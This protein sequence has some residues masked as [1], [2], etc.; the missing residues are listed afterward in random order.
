MWRKG[1]LTYMATIHSALQAGVIH[2][3]RLPSTEC[4]D[5]LRPLYLADDVFNWVETTDGLH[6]PKWSPKSGGRSR[7]EHLMQTFADFRC[8][9]RPLV[10]DLTRLMPNK[11]GVW[12]MHS[13]GLRLLG[14]VPEPHSFV[15][16]RLALTEYTHG[17][18]STVNDLMNEVVA[19]AK[20]QGLHHT[21]KSGDRSA[22]FPSP[23]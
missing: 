15:G 1:L 14:W 20:A 16:V 21:F 11:K 2:E 5:P 3:F 6:D 23:S 8:D 9:Q 17:A 18:A 10:G 4:R 19:F 13:K 7:F 22:L 12:S